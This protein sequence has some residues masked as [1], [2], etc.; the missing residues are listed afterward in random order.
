[1]Q[2]ASSDDIAS[3]GNRQ[4]E[5]VFFAQMEH[6]RQPPAPSCKKEEQPFSNSRKRMFR[7]S[8][9]CCWPAANIP[10]I[11]KLSSSGEMV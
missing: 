1:M 2:Y 9:F 10:S 11:S 4:G 3:S 6:L 8:W 7:A 5:S